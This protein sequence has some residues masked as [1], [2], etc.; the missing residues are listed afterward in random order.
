[1]ISE[2]EAKRVESW[3]NEAI[4]QGAKVLTGGGRRFTL[5]EPTI[6]DEPPQESD[7]VSREAFAPV[8]SVMGVG[9]VDQAVRLVN[10]SPYGLQAGIFTANILTAFKEIVRP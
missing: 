8:V 1:M 3:V 6:L 2:A 4:S 9:D 5:F 7:I 10:D